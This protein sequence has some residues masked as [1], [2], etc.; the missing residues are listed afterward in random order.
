MLLGAG[1]LLALLVLAL[2]AATGP[3]YQ[4]GLDNLNSEQ[5]ID[6]F[7]FSSDY[8]EGADNEKKGNT[9]KIVS[10]WAPP[11]LHTEYT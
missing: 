4:K 5:V 11:S 3:K 1:A 6:A 9:R 10:A 7:L 8:I 2:E